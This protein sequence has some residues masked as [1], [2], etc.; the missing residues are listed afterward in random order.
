MKEQRFWGGGGGSLQPLFQTLAPF[1]AH[2]TGTPEGLTGGGGGAEVSPTKMT[3][4]DPPQC[5][6]HSEGCIVGGILFRKKKSSGPLRSAGGESSLEFLDWPLGTGCHESRSPPP[7]VQGAQTIP[8]P[9]G[10]PR[11]VGPAGNLTTR[12]LSGGPMGLGCRENPWQNSL[13]QS[14]V[15]HCPNHRTL[16]PPLCQCP[17]PPPPKLRFHPPHLSTDVDC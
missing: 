3:Q 6:A 1:R 7:P 2:L 16:K 5:A 11:M 15:H 10:M 9:C 4:T 8:P 12:R 17:P 13:R 14:P